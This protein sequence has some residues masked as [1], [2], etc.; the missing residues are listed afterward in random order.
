MTYDSGYYS[1]TKMAETAPGT[2][3][4]TPKETADAFTTGANSLMIGGGIFSA[5]STL[6]AMRVSKSWSGKKFKT[7]GPWILGVL[8]VLIL[9][10]MVT[11]F[12]G[13]EKLL[14]ENFNPDL[15]H[16]NKWQIAALGVS[17][18]STLMVFITLIFSC[19]SFFE[20]DKAPVT[21]QH[22]VPKPGRVDAPQANRPIKVLQEKFQEA[23][24]SAAAGGRI[25][26][27][28]PPRPLP[29]P[30][31]T[32][33]RSTTESRL[34]NGPSD[35]RRRPP[36][37]ADAARRRQ[38]ESSIAQIGEGD[39]AAILRNLHRAAQ[40]TSGRRSPGADRTAAAN[41][42]RPRARSHS[43]PGHRKHNGVHHRKDE[44]DTSEQIAQVLHQKILQ[45][46]PEHGTREKV[47]GLLQLD[48]LKSFIDVMLNQFTQNIIPLF[49][50]QLEIKGQLAVPV[51]V[52][53]PLGNSPAGG[54][55]TN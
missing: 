51:E 45:K 43:D 53:I 28:Q 39:R 55:G 15:H 40:K 34:R 13:V 38:E 11:G 6:G 5:L 52:S 20:K 22:P 18:G 4:P 33:D 32:P 48:F 21:Q 3:V 12:L 42:T 26:D 10:M 47:R 24:A 31:S 25:D 44:T 14:D 9:V 8:L 54:P 7:F 46:L 29:P 36:E 35:S 27:G 17:G 23:L 19:C 49:L 37:A 50:H 30:P 16:I 41:V 1:T 2:V